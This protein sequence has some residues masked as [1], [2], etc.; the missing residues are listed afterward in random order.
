MWRKLNDCSKEQTISGSEGKPSH[1][2]LTRIHKLHVQVVRQLRDA[3][4]NLIEL[5]PLLPAIAL[6][7][8]HVCWLLAVGGGGVLVNATRDLAFYLLSAKGGAQFAAKSS[9][10]GPANI[11]AGT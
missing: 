5:H 10:A 9:E 11:A 7:D 2:S 4:R 3:R 6:D 8:E 1:R